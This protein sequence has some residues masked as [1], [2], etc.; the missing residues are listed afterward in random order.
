MKV[1]VTGGAG[2]IGSIMVQMLLNNDHE[3]VIVDR[4]KNSTVE[5]N[6]RAKFYQQDILDMAK[7]EEIL[8]TEQPNA[9]IHF[10]GLISMEEST[11]KPE[12]YFKVNTFGSLSL[13][14]AMLNAG[15]N[16]L[17]FSS[18]AGVYGNTDVV[19]I[20]ESGVKKPTNPYGESKLLVEQ[21]LLWFWRTKN[22]SS[23]SLRYYNL[24]GASSDGSL[25]ETHEPETHIIPLALQAAQEGAE[26]KLFGD[27]Y[28]TTDGTC[29]R[30]YI[31]VVDLC[32]A[33]LMALSS[34]INDPRHDAYNV[35]TGRGWS[36][37][38]VVDTV[39]KITQKELLVKIEVRRPGDAAELVADSTK[40]K[41]ALG[42]K[43][44][45][46]DLAEIVQ[47]AWEYA[48]KQ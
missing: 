31:H 18:S 39:K 13:I 3:V 36:N 34:L 25:G 12:L 17:I 30:D 48:G 14:T 8:K 26:F 45:H 21:M 19:P 7:L 24:A 1:L 10:A 38:Q 33:H 42:W 4:T 40:I 22:L 27:D 32:Q 11:R 20:V 16:N 44:Q 41:Q 47:S 9:V 2:Y 6:K 46:S 5:A 15:I 29:V 28:P 43:P 35:G 23:L 37:R